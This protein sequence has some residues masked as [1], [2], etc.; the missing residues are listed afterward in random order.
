MG[1]AEARARKRVVRFEASELDVRASHWGLAIIPIAVLSFSIPVLTYV[2]GAESAWPFSLSKFAAAYGVAEEYVPQILVASSLLACCVAGVA[3]VWA[4]SRQQAAN[5]T[6]C[7]SEVVG[8]QARTGPVVR[9]F[10]AGVKE[11]AVPVLILIAAWMLGAAISQLGTATWLC[12]ALQGR[13][14]VV[15]LP[16]GFGLVAGGLVLWG[17]PTVWRT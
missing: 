8:P 15:M 10:L 14:P 16:A 3:Y 4:R 1:A 11:I 5:H 13:L 17:L 6:S 12:E 7:V 9:V 2:I